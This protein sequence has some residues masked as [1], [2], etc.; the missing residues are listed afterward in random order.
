M[1]CQ[2][3]DEFTGEACEAEIPTAGKHARRRFCDYHRKVRQN[4]SVH[5]SLARQA[6]KDRVPLPKRRLASKDWPDRRAAIIAKYGAKGMSSR[7]TTGRK[8]RHAK[9]I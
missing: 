3:I 5:R 9:R 6:Y 7:G 1:N 4:D 2:H 8:V